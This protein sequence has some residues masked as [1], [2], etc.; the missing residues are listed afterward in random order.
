MHV[1]DIDGNSKYGGSYNSPTMQFMKIATYYKQTLISYQS[2]NKQL[3][4]EKTP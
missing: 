2:C 1:V 4:I 3:T